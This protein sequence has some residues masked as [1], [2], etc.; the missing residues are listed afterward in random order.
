MNLKAFKF[1]LSIVEVKKE[2]LEFID[3]FFLNTYSLCYKVYTFK[4][5]S[6]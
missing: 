2:T 1:L 5:T 6:F 4:I 3:F